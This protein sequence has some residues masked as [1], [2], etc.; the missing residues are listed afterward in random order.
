M[1]WNAFLYSKSLRFHEIIPISTPIATTLRQWLS[2]SLSHLISAAI[3][4]WKYLFKMILD[5]KK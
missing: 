3:P 5:R 4:I 1:Y 2:L